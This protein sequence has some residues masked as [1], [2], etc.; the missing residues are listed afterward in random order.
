M[1]GKSVARLLCATAVLSGW[2]YGQTTTAGLT[3]AITDPSG[4][5]TPGF[6]VEL[7]NAATGASTDT[8][9][10]AGGNFTF[11]SLAPATYSLT[12]TPPAGFKSYVQTG[13][14]VTPNETRDLGRIALSLGPATEQVTVTAIATPL[15]A[16]SSE[17]SKLVDAAQILDLTLKGRDL[18]GIL[19]TIP[20]ITTAEQDTTSESS[21]ASV[22]INGAQY[23]GLV[24]F[25]VDGIT[26]LDTANNTGLHYEP[27]MDSIAEMRVLASNYQAEYGRNSSGQISVVTKSGGQ[28]FHGSAWA[29]KRH[30]MFNATSFFN[31]YNGVQKSVYR[32][33]VWGYSIGGPV[34]IPGRWN[35]QKKRL[36]FFLSQEYTRQKPATETGYYNTPTA[37]QRQG[38]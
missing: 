21:I 2:A 33:F 10:G 22:R 3:G 31:N 26:D 19:V 6:R 38:N 15:A 34:F 20:G 25:V 9:T 32:F 1:A 27:N 7:K 5:G 13:I 24:N 18:F 16:A 36:F 4:A 8:T 11:N 30:E 37:A 17:N 12:V 23:P 29:N 14:A 28:E 35:T